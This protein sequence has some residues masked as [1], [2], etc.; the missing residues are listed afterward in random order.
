VILENLGVADIAPQRVHALVAGL[1]G[2]LEDRGERAAS[3]PW[4]VSYPLASHA[5]AL[6]PSKGPLDASD[7]RATCTADHLPPRAA[8]MPRS[9]NA[10]AMARND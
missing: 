3:R 5:A 6:A 8:G 7:K 9:F 2:H 1:I 10:A 4:G